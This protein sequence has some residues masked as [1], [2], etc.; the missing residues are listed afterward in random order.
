MSVKSATEQFETI[1]FSY[2]YR[3]YFFTVHVGIYYKT[4]EARYKT[5]E[6]IV[7][8]PMPPIKVGI[9][10]LYFNKCNDL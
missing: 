9:S 2:Y 6:F 10:K 1:C 5:P 3:F 8:A 7:T 4:S